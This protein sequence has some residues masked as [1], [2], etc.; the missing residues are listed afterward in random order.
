[1][2]GELK[3]RTTSF[4]SDSIHKLSQFLSC[5]SSIACSIPISSAWKAVE[6]P[7]FIVK[8]LTNHQSIMISKKSSTTG[9][10][11]TTKSC[12]VCVP[13]SIDRVNNSCSYSQFTSSSPTK[14]PKVSRFI[15][16]GMDIQSASQPI[17]N[18]CS[19]RAAKEQM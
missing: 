8:Q 13:D 10:T 9:L 17:P 4:E 7:K 11:R 3:A 2:E 1:M 6:M 14:V 19:K 18:V 16:M 12:A 5:A 15:N